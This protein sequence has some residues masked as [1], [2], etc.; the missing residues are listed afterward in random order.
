MKHSDAKICISPGSP[1]LQRGKV[2]YN[3]LQGWNFHLE[4]ETFTSPSAE[5]RSYLFLDQ[6]TFQ[7]HIRSPKFLH[8]AA[9]AKP[10]QS[11]L[12]LCDPIDVNPAGSSVPGILQ[13]RILEWLAISF[14][15]AWKWKV[16]VKSLSHAQPFATPWTVAH[17]APPSMESTG[18]EASLI[19]NCLDSIWG[20]FYKDTQDR[21]INTF[22]FSPL[23]S[24]S[25]CD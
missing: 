5:K 14:S 3:W 22:P 11:Y 23:T 17:Q 6:E 10:R 13:A 2:S 24:S 4:V 9:A 16:K 20:A 18:N 12:T 7:T 15:N 1:D 8:A 25:Q 21:I 19:K